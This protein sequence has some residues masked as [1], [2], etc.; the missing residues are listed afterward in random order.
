MEALFKHTLVTPWRVVLRSI[1]LSFIGLLGVGK[2]EAANT[3][4]VIIC[5]RDAPA[6]VRLAAREV[7]RY[8]YLRT[9]TRT[10]AD[11]APN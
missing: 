8:I 9:A 11:L 10:Y 4:G 2:S 3:G 5:R 1:F 7:R 6:N